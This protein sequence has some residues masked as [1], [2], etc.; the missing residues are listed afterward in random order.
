MEIYSKLREAEEKK[1]MWVI[2]HQ[3]AKP[4][5]QCTEVASKEN[6]VLGQTR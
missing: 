5:W 3:N 2:L 1:D 6:K 4:Y